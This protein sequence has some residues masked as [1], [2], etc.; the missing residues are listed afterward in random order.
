M[1]TTD[2]IQIIGTAAFAVSGVVVTALAG[3]MHVQRHHYT[4]FTTTILIA[5]V[6]VSSLPSG[7]D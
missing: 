5:D 6:S 1:T 7:T 3:M 2:F 4:H